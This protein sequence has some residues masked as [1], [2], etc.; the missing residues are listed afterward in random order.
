MAEPA[1]SVPPVIPQNPAAASTG[2]LS[3]A[4]PPPVVA[5]GPEADNVGNT[6]NPDVKLS[7]INW[8]LLT[9][10]ADLLRW[11]KHFLLITGAKGYG[12]F[13]DGSVPPGDP[14]WSHDSA[15]MAELMLLGSIS[16]E[17]HDLLD[18]APS[19]YNNTYLRFQYL[20]DHFGQE[21]RDR[22]MQ[23]RRALEGV[24]QIQGES[25]Q[26]LAVRIT[27]LFKWIRLGREQDAPTEAAND[28]GHAYNE[29]DMKFYLLEAARLGAYGKRYK[30]TC[31]AL[32]RDKT[33]DF[34]AC[35]RDLELD[36]VQA[37]F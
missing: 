35:V 36:E 7:G 5:P 32:A 26:T 18:A 3:G 4:T 12:R 6:P 13:F 1:T 21:I 9:S 11:K 19:G 15:A 22:Q 14:L 23:S 31:K 34:A 33:K 29:A 17:V 30:E 10:A 8:K 27:K 24:K 37:E 16:D 25:I 20:C 2:D 28:T